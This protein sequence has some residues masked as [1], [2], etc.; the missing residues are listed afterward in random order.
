MERNSAARNLLSSQAWTDGRTDGRKPVSFY[1]SL[2]LSLSLPL[3][4]TASFPSFFLFFFFF[5]TFHINF[6]RNDDIYFSCLERSRLKNR[7][8]CKTRSRALTRFSLL[9]Y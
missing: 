6:S 4:F 3:S 9:R 8:E 7:N 2:S 1:R 5:S